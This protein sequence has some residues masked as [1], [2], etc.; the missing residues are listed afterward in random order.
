MDNK[1]KKRN[2][3]MDVMRLVS[4]ILI[5]GGHITAYNW[6]DTSA[7][8]FK[9]QVLNISD[10]IC[11]LGVPMF[12]MMSGALHLNENYELTIKNVITKKFFRMFLTYYC[13]LLYYNV[14]SFIQNGYEWNFFNIKFYIIGHIVRGQGIYHLW[15][16]PKLMFMYLLTPVI[17][18]GLKEKKT[19]LYTLIFYVFVIIGLPTL[20]QFN[21]PGK[22]WIEY[23]F[24]VDKFMAVTSTFGYLGYY[25]AG[26][27]VH[28]FIN[29][30]N[31]K[32]RITAYLA[33]V[34][35]TVLAIYLGYRNTVHLGVADTTFINPLYLPEFL[36]GIALFILF[37]DWCQNKEEK[38]SP[39]WLKY[40]G[41]LTFGIYLFHPTVI[42]F[43]PY[44]GI[45]VLSPQ[46]YIM[47]PVLVAAVFI[48][49]LGVSYLLNKIPVVNKWLL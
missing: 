21:F 23:N 32:V 17:K 44:L 16:I 35:S 24:D 47:I 39:E 11:A 27:Y 2:V 9:Y 13:W 41:K 34:I 28:S 36:G 4:C 5:I 19:T 22:A 33:L 45:S 31:K 18:E 6:N 37:K 46:P 48:I 29:E 49:S 7:G 40:V 1:L 43:F 20:F 25:I 15:F 10:N 12:I 8:S 14:F 30:I 3:Y 38:G 26:H 42:N